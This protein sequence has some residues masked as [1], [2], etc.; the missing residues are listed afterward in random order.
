MA[1]A[2]GLLGNEWT[3]LILQRAL[4]GTTRYSG[5]LHELPISN[6][7]LTSR[8]NTLVDEGLLEHRIYQRNPIRAEYRLTDRGRSVWSILLAIWDWERTW[9][10]HQDETLPTMSHTPCGCDFRP[11]LACTACDKAVAVQDVSTS[12]G[13]S[14]SW[15]RSSADAMTRR[16]SGRRA[17]PV[18][19][20]ETMEAFGDRWSSSMIGAAFL[21]ICRFSEF[22]SALSMPPSLVADRLQLFVAQGVLT[23]VQHGQRA[24]WVEYHLTEKGRAFFPVVMLMLTWAEKWY[25]SEE[26]PALIHVHDDCQKEFVPTLTCSHCGRRLKGGDVL[27][28]TAQFA[29]GAS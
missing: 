26:G 15:A 1:R 10:S 28:S 16:R 24:N 14:G 21:G 5:F 2:L 17:K 4:L 25:R 27:P 23:T 12:W 6:S 9:V 22:Q 18:F 8:L 7:V 11:V 20:P 29:S 19:F 3:V 13:P